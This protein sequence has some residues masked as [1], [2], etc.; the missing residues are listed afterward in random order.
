[1]KTKLLLTILSLC[2][3][4]YANAQNSWSGKANFGGTAREGAAGFY[5]E[6]TGKGY[7]G[8]GFDNSTPQNFQD[9]WEY[10]Q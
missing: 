1:M 8:T 6:S 4:L 5:I 7:I 3:F 9:F 10:C 2:I